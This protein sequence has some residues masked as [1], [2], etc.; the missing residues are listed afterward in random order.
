[1]RRFAH[2]VAL[3]L[4]LCLT[5][6]VQAAPRQ[7]LEALRAQLE[8]LSKELADS[9]ESRAE[10]ADQLR[11]SERAISEARLQL[12]E[13]GQKQTSLERALSDLGAQARKT[14]ADLSRQRD[15]LA[16]MLYHRYLNGHAE[17]LQLVMGRQN[18]NELARRLHYLT[19]LSRERAHLIAD[20]R[21]DLAELERITGQ[22]RTK[23][24]ELAAI[25]QDQT[26]QQRALERERA[27]RQKVL[28]NVSVQINQQKKQLAV[29]QRDE[30]RLTRLVEKLARAMARPQ[31]PKKTDRGNSNTAPIANQIVPEAGDD[32]EVFRRLRGKLRLPVIGELGSRFGSPPA[33]S[34]ISSKGIFIRAK[35]GQEVKA[36][37]AGRVV[38]ADWLR[39][40][41]NMLIV[42]HGGGYMSI[43]GN[44]EAL[45]RRAG[46]VVRAG[47][48]IATVGASGGNEETGL[49]FELR[50]EG[51]PFDPL[52]WA[53]L[54]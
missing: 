46:E 53:R 32:D 38:F 23:A 10:A 45:Y 28:A 3:L 18:P 7:D 16:R 35:S 19:Y 39:G 26:A 15:G 52:T 37:A 44:N 21:K 2:L 34:G 25:R 13:L 54:R 1:M 49:Y 42:D 29:L 4:A 40:F 36:V 12:R 51:R 31:T 11:D 43:Y 30:Q 8:A 6:A 17:P 9:E 5:A 50:H 48:A 20:L 24:E 27:T 41:G 47:D 14:K 33:A 22:T